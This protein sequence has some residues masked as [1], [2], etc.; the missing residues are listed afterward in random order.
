MTAQNK[1]TQA[2]QLDARAT[3]DDQRSSFALAAGSA[4]GRFPHSGIG[5]VMVMLCFPWLMLGLMLTCKNWDETLAEWHQ[6]IFGY[7]LI[8]PP[9]AKVCREAGNQN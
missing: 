9:N 3:N 6:R 7:P 8:D 2:S 1:T 4:R 5:L